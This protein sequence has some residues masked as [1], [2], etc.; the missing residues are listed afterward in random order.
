MH[1]DSSRCETTKVKVL[2][3]PTGL[4]P[5]PK[6]SFTFKNDNPWVSHEGGAGESGFCYEA[7]ASVEVA[8]EDALGS[9]GWGHTEN[10]EAQRAKH[11]AAHGVEADVD[12]K[13]A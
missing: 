12:S 3:S 9:G 5:L 10:T 6:Y 8:P 2:A 1:K 4:S 7:G 13:S 11:S